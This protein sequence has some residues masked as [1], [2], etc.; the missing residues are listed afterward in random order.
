MAEEVDLTSSSWKKVHR[1]GWHVSR[2]GRPNRNTYTTADVSR[3]AHDVTPIK[4]L[5]VDASS[6]PVK[7]DLEFNDKRKIHVDVMD[8]SLDPQ[9]KETS[10]HSFRLTERGNIL[11]L[12]EL[13][14]DLIHK[15]VKEIEV[16]PETPKQIAAARALSEEP[17]RSN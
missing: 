2:R 3:L 7:V 8:T 17:E 12:M 13:L 16:E 1:Q 9:T 4:R 11:K 14:I 6:L 15:E 10:T 5:K